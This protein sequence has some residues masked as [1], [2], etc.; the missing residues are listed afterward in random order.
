MS[1]QVC[2]ARM[3]RVRVG[4]EIFFQETFVVRILLLRWQIHII[5]ESFITSRLIIKLS[6]TLLTKPS[7]SPISW[8][9][10]QLYLLLFLGERDISTNDDEWWKNH[11]SIHR[12]IFTFSKTTSAECTQHNA[13]PMISIKSIRETRMCDNVITSHEIISIHRDTNDRMIMRWH[14]TQI[15]SH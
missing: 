14:R 10:A 7:P 2:A 1:R 15:Q 3:K 6:A 5:V 4:T 13:Q 8:I 9:Y 12:Q 11:R